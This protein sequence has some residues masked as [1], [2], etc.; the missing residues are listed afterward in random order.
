ME[1]TRRHSQ[2][3]QDRSQWEELA[4]PIHGA[5]DPPLG[6]S[7]RQALSCEAEPGGAEQDQ[8]EPEQRRELPDSSPQFQDL[9]SK[10]RL[11]E[12]GTIQTDD[13]RRRRAQPPTRRRARD[14]E[15]RGEGHVAGAADEIA[16]PMV[17]TRRLLPAQR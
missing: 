10:L 6:A 7:V 3:P 11:C 16:K 5:Q 13:G 12:I 8:R 1:P 14:A 17:I 9:L 2:E 15:V 4:G